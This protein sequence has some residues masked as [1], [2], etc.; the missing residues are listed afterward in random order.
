MK[1]VLIIIGT[2]PEAIKM[3]PVYYALKRSALPVVICSTHQHAELLSSVFKIFD[4]APDYELHVMKAGQDLYHITEAVLTGLKP[5]I[6]K[7]NPALVL[8]QGDTT[9]AFA[10]ALAAFYKK[11]PILH[12]EA[13]LRSQKLDRPF[14]EE[15]NR[16]LI[17][18][19]ATYHCAPTI[20]AQRNLISENVPADSIFLTGNTVVD[21]LYYIQNKIKEHPELITPQLTAIITQARTDQKKI[22][23]LTMHRREL[24]DGGM[25][26]IIKALK[27][28]IEEHPRIL[29]VYPLHPNPH[30]LAYIKQ[31]NL[32]TCDQLLLCEPLSYIQCIYTLSLVDFVM[33]DSGGI[34]EE[35]TVL[36]KPTLLLRNEDCVERHEA[37]EI[38]LARVAGINE[39]LIIHEFN[40]LIYSFSKTHNYEGVYGDGYAAEKIVAIIQKYSE[41]C[42]V[43]NMTTIC[44]LGLGYIGL[45]TALVAAEH[46]YQVVGFDIDHKRV[47]NINSGNAVIQESGIDIKLKTCLEQGAFYATTTLQTA[48]IYIIAVPTPLTEE[49]KADLSYV[50]NAVS[51]I[52]HIL[53][54]GDTIIV[55]STVPVG[56]TEKVANFLEEKTGLNKEIDFFCAHCPERVL[57][58]NIFYEL[59]H[60]SRIIGGINTISSAHVLKFY[61]KFVKGE[62]TTTTAAEAEMVKLIE[63]SYRD[64]MLAFSY[65]LTTLAREA[66]LNVYNLIELANKHPRVSIL[67]P[68]AGVGG[69]CIAIDPWFLVESFPASTQLIKTAREVN[70]HRPIAIYQSITEALQK[71]Q[72]NNPLQRAQVLVLGATYKPNVDDLRESPA[73][74]IIKKLSQ[75]TDIDL[76]ICEPHVNQQTLFSHGLNTI[77]NFEDGIQKADI[78]ACLVDHTYFIEHSV[79]LKHHP[80]VL[81]FCGLTRFTQP[82]QEH[83]PIQLAKFNHH[84]IQR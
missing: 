82:M 20:T 54:K 46:G 5:L 83:N 24:F 40:R 16:R 14:P 22:I 15:M 66:D 12:V 43:K 63:N 2:R 29:I 76:M 26:T 6:E 78:V 21:A 48:D 74:H 77:S 38:G 31:T 8:V 57:P 4:V 3:I 47:E 62:L 61:K 81:D 27:K 28:I 17:A 7:I 41:Y 72:S 32:A 53:K 30:I 51:R 65:E 13:G 39:H 55:E 64:V 70:D 73:L 37:I 79:Q 25:I 18:R 10:G 56:T 1:P 33:T 35:A 42:E 67:H 23:F 11:I 45:P 58:G 60:N 9:T 80:C 59:V 84:E 49:K 50:W 36:G 34:Q 44:V 75:H 19:L 69:H 71:W 52:A 68:R